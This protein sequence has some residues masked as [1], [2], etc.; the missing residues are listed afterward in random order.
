MSKWRV[1]VIAVVWVKKNSCSPKRFICCME[2]C[3]A[4]KLSRL[5][6]IECFY[7]FR[8]V[9]APCLLGKVDCSAST[10]SNRQEVIS[11]GTKLK[12]EV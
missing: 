2:F 7:S 8:R 3:N 4:I 11:V 6:R 9:G 12:V 5:M 10:L 1:A